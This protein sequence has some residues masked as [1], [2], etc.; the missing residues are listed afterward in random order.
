MAER[1]G[2]G[3]ASKAFVWSLL[4]QGGSK[5]IQL[6]VQII[7]ARILNPDAFGVL[8]IL[9]VV[10]QVA[11]SVAQSGL[12][13]GLVQKLDADDIS[14]STA[15]WLSLGLAL[16]MYTFILMAAPSIAAFYQMAELD[17][18]LRVLGAIV[19]FNSANSIQRSYLQRSMDFRSIFRATTVAA[20]L[21]SVVGIGLALAGAGVWALVAQSLSQS[22]FI[23][24]MMWVQ[25]AWKPRAVFDCR[26]AREIFGYGW[27][28]CITGIL[29]VFYQGIS[30]LILGRVTSASELGY[31]SNGRKYP[32]AAIGVLTNAL[33]NVL[34]PSFASLKT[35]MPSLRDAMRKALRL[36][37]FLIVPSSVVC[38]IVAEPLVAI[39]L[40]NQW[41][42]CVPVF[43]LACLS[44]V[45]TMM[46]LVNLRAYMALGDSALY[47][48]INIIK[49]LFGGGAI[50]VTAAISHSIYAAAAATFAVNILGVL[51]VDA[52]SARRVHGYTEMEQIRDQL[53]VFG[54]TIVASGISVATGL[55]PLSDACTLVFQIVSFITVYLASAWALKFD[56][57]NQL[58]SIARRITGRSA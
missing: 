33:A 31:Y 29:N 15:W 45:T 35:D 21:S 23:C 16:V 34:F 6:V 51:L 53:P 56:E 41:L 26:Q 19:L 2:T 11:D 55:L 42:P 57:L 7:L 28:I 43:Q 22:V 36:G 1:S 58:G 30:E 54:I 3:S 52:H 27:K 40:G 20:L 49:V 25:V 48:R 13:L 37:S 24:M 8:A 9:L 44:N 50:W 47:M 10:T 18:Y 38:A 39:L 14:Y 32:S 4:E 5:A 46:M 12:G 17:I